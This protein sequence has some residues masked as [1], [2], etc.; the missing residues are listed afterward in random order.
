[1][2]SFRPHSATDLFLVFYN[3]M[4]EFVVDVVECFVNVTANRR[5]INCHEKFAF[6]YYD[7]SGRNFI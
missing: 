1:M 3:F 2:A 4:G 6:S 7:F 5:K